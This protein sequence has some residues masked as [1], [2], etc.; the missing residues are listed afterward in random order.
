[1]TWRCPTCKAVNWSTRSNCRVKGCAGRQPS[2]QPQQASKK[3]QGPPAGGGR[4]PAAPSA[5]PEKP[6]KPESKETAALVKHARDLQRAAQSATDDAAKREL[7]EQA[8]Q[9]HREVRGKKPLAVQVQNCESAIE[10]AQQRLDAK[11]KDLEQAQKA[12]D[13]EEAVLAGYQ[14]DLADLKREVAGQIY[15]NS[16]GAWRWQGSNWQGWG[17][18][19]GDQEQEGQE[20]EEG[21]AEGDHSMANGEYQPDGWYEDHVGHWWY[22]DSSSAARST[23]WPSSACAHEQADKVRGLEEAVRQTNEAMAEIQNQVTLALSGLTTQLAE[24]ANAAVT[25]ALA[26]QTAVPGAADK[27]RGNAMGAFGRQSRRGRGASMPPGAASP[28]R[29]RSGTRSSHPRT[30]TPA[31]AAAATLEEGELSDGKQQEVGFRAA[32][33]TPTGR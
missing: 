15:E 3:Q 1:M 31:T 13:D 30:P 8:R 2:A 33:A 5:K 11:R 6:E 14:K 17:E 22:A 21:D 32:G 26:Q 29:S 7:E 9:A 25:Q 18:G 10:R 20:Q 23:S 24:T 12:V 27:P 16:W 4:R 28:P 19:Q